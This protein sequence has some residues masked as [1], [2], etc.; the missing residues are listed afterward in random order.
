MIDAIELPL[1]VRAER[2]ARAIDE[3]GLGEPE[4][5]PLSELPVEQGRWRKS[6]LGLI[7]GLLRTDSD[8]IFGLVLTF[9]GN[10]RFKEELRPL[11]PLRICS[12]R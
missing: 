7:G 6:I 10:L 2:V 5:Y 3:L 8:S 9:A 12:W 4:T 1:A 11:S